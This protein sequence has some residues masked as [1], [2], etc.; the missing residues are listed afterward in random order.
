MNALIEETARNPAEPEKP[1]SSGGSYSGMTSI[2]LT[3]G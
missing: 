1:Q 3:D 2:A